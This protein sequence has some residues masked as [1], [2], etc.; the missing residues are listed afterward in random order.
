ML[1]ALKRL[2]GGTIHLPNRAKDHP[3]RDR[4]ARC[5]WRSPTQ[6]GFGAAVP[7]DVESI[8]RDNAASL[9]ITDFGFE[10]E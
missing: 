10:G 5:I 2:N 7:E 4:L 1:E 8:V 3:Y 6:N 9:R